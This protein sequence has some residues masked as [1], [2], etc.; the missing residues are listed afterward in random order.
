MAGSGI[1]A[2]TGYNGVHVLG[3]SRDVIKIH[4]SH[5][6]WDRGLTAGKAEFELSFSIGDPADDPGIRDLG[7]ITACRFLCNTRYVDNVA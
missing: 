4:A 5:F 7:L 2:H 6:N 1:T 3:P